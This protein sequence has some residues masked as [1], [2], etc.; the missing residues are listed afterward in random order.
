M[1]LAS[2]STH[3]SSRLWRRWVIDVRRQ[4]RLWAPTMQPRMLG[5]PRSFRRDLEISR[6]SSPEYVSRSQL[7][8]RTTSSPG[9][10]GFNLW[11][12]NVR[13]GKRSR[14]LRCRRRLT[15]LTNFPIMRL[16]AGLAA[17]TGR[18]LW[19]SS[20]P[21]TTPCSSVL[22]KMSV[23]RFSMA[24]SV[25][26]DR[27]SQLRACFTNK[28]H[29]GGSG[30]DSGRSMAQSTGRPRKRVMEKRESFADKR[31]QAER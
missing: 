15:F 18:V 20:P 7:W 13:S 2:C 21:I 28:P 22:L 19:S 4:W 6:R 24:L 27:S 12:W 25:V 8:V 14:R 31:P 29:R 26:A 23:C 3:R 10:V 17:W 5:S 16:P 11:N 30:R 1:P 9:P